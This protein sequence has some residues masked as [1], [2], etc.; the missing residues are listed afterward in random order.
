MTDS[1]MNILGIVM[2]DMEKVM[3]QY[4]KYEYY[5]YYSGNVGKQKK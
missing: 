1:G 5:G 3:P 2:N 4:Y